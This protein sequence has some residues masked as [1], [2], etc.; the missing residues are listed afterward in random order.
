MRDDYGYFEEDQLGRVGDTGLW[1][2]I[3]CLGLPEWPG[4]VLAVLLSLLVA[5]CALAL[6]YLLRLAI[7]DFVINTDLDQAVRLAGLA[8]LAGLFLLIMAVG[9]VVNFFQVL[10]LAWTG[11]T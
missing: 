9:F 7:D 4:A 3:I 6:P 1:R 11:S 10:I 2:R 5:A 8:R